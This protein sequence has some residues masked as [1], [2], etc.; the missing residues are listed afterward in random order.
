MKNAGPPAGS[1]YIASRR[2]SSS[3]RKKFFG[4]NVLAFAFSNHAMITAVAC[5]L[6]YVV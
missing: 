6:A 4:G 1:I 2:L 5:R 3:F